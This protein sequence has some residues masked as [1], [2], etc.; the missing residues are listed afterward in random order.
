MRLW[1]GICAVML[2]YHDSSL[3]WNCTVGMSHYYRAAVLWYAATWYL[4]AEM[5]D[6]GW[7]STVQYNGDCDGQVWW[8]MRG[9]SADVWQRK[10][11]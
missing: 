6:V 5:P 4:I 2:V 11:Y 8:L 7:Y 10:K 1:Y 3:Q 9:K